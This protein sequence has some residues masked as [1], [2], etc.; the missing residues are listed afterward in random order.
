MYIYGFIL[1]IQVVYIIENQAYGIPTFY[2]KPPFER[3]RIC[4]I[5]I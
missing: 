2:E 1:N 4:K 5:L 3:K